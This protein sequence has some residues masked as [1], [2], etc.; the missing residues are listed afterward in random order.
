MLLCTFQ[1]PIKAH[2]CTNY[3]LWYV[4][5]KT[6]VDSRTLHAYED[7]QIN[8]SPPWSPAWKNKSMQDSKFKID[9]RCS[10]F[11]GQ[12]LISLFSKIV[13]SIC[14]ICIILQLILSFLIVSRTILAFA[15]GTFPV[16]WQFKKPFQYLREKRE[17]K[18]RKSHLSNAHKLR[19]K[20]ME[21][22]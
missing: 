7:A 18:R 8:T 15:V 20:A 4:D 14:N 13:S 10:Y 21:K 6:S 2:Q 5:S 19:A 22:E 12:K 16:L 9:S 11:T 17:K 3:H 1:S